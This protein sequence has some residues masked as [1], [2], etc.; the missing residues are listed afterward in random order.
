M[1]SSAHNFWPW[2]ATID[3]TALTR[4]AR[5]HII[6]N[7]VAFCCWSMCSMCSTV[8]GVEVAISKGTSKGQEH[9]KAPAAHSVSVHLKTAWPGG[10]HPTS[11]SG[12]LSKHRIGSGAL[13]PVMQ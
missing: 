9:P 3:K 5:G 12:Q 7:S 8:Y 10:L 1:S 11:R 4:Q 13:G 6:V 2:K